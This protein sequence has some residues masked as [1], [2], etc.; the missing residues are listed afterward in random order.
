MQTST[1]KLVTVVAEA[2][3]EDELIQEVYAA[4]AKG[5]TLD[6]VLGEGSRGVRASDWAGKNV[7]I[8]TLVAPEVADKLLT[9]LAEKYFPHYAVVAYVKSVEVVRGD[10]YR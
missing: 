5:Y 7:K 3:L 6:R 2:V 9:V 8:E 4:G 10:K 1:M